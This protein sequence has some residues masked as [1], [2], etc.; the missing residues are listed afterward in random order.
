MISWTWLLVLSVQPL[1]VVLHI[2]FGSPSHIKPLLEVGTVLHKR[3]H[4]VIFA[5]SEAHK[6]FH[7]GYPFSFVSLGKKDEDS[8][9]ARQF[10]QNFYDKRREVDEFNMLP[11]FLE[12]TYN[13]I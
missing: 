2:D 7:T 9:S 4:T 6:G 13:F 3:N 5:A 10:M 12:K 1:K 11:L 8:K